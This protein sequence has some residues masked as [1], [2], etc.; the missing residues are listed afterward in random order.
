MRCRFPRPLL[1]LALLLGALVAPGPAGALAAAPLQPPLVTQVFPRDSAADVSFVADTDP[2]ITGFL[3]AA[4][5]GGTSVRVPAGARTARV[6][7]LTNGTA[8]R[9]TVRQEVSRGRALLSDPS[10]QATPRPARAPGEPVLGAVHAR[11]RAVEVEWTA[12][13]DGG[14]PITAFTVT[15]TPGG[16]RVTVGPDTASAALAGLANGTAY[17][18]AVR[19]VNKAGPGTPAEQSRVRPRPDT[20]P[21]A[22]IDV[23]ASPDGGRDSAL[24]VTWTAPADD[25]GSPVTGYRVT[26]GG[27][28]VRTA[29]AITEA[30]ID[31]LSPDEEYTVSVA[32]AN[33]VGT[34]PAART[35]EAVAPRVDVAARTVVLSAASMATLTGKELGELRFTNPTRQLLGLR[36]G[37]IVVADTSPQAPD[38]LLRTVNGVRRQGTALVVA[39]A[40]ADLS[41]V[42]TDAQVSAAGELTNEGAEPGYLHPGV[43]AEPVTVGNDLAFGLTIRPGDNTREFAGLSTNISGTVTLDPHWDLVVRT[44]GET[45]P[46]TGEDIGEVT[47]VTFAA[48]VDVKASVTAT[49]AGT[50]GGTSQAVTLASLP[51]AAITVP[52]GPVPVVIV[53]TLTLSAQLSVSGSLELVATATYEQHI[54]GVADFTLQ[55]GWSGRSTTT[56]PVADLTADRLSPGVTAQLDLPSA[57]SF[58]LYGAIG[59]GLQFVPYLRFVTAPTENPWAHLDAGVRVEVTGGIKKLNLEYAVPVADFSRTVW[60]AEGPLAGIYIENPTRVLPA[61]G[62]T[63]FAVSRRN[64]C[65]GPVFWSLAE[66]SPGTITGDGV[67]TYTAS[68]TGPALAKIIATQALTS[69]CAGTSAQAFVQT[70]STVPSAP[71][72]LTL[73]YR[74]GDAVFTW[75]PPENDGNAGRVVY[76]LVADVPGV[77]PDD[78]IVYSYDTTA[79]LP[80]AERSLR[81]DGGRFRVIAENDVG[82]GPPGPDLVAPP[83][84]Y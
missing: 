4:S 53:P 22:P 42:L 63:A 28:T 47:D 40:D 31:G 69:N 1:V 77:D 65:E 50:V 59:P 13:D 12:P 78:S 67:Y 33:A 14:A 60:S 80:G 43:R 82:T 51:L 6:T 23:S 66:G 83:E 21:A 32:A 25:G 35:E 48:D 64:W 29:A 81:A 19:A 76:S 56:D 2:V 15:A 24:R 70:G 54:G 57:I 37:Q 55:D 73:D 79:T 20:V 34:G 38:G 8:Y 10:E 46:D 68:G 3:V 84:D 30:V 9:F 41:R 49:V 45:D 7:G 11:N 74:H 27:T 58:E 39:T 52:V 71:R 44:T 17:T 36:A 18:V 72:G 61:S 16:H 75:D 5:P 62:S 26:A